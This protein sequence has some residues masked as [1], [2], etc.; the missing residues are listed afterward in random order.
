M[1]IRLDEQMR[2]LGT[3]QGVPLSGVTGLMR[4]L[5]GIPGLE[6]PQRRV[7]VGTGWSNPTV[8][9]VVPGLR[10]ETVPP[11]INGVAQIVLDSMVVRLRD[12]LGFLSLNGQFPLATFVDVLGPGRVA[13]SGDLV[14]TLVWSTSWNGFVSGV[15]RT[16]MVV[17][18]ANSV[19]DTEEG[20][21]L[22]LEATTRHQVKP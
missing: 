17:V 20:E 22:V 7:S 14:G 11:T 13:A 10:N 4:I 19:D 12:T 15:S 9:S 8:A 18:R 5:T 6:L 16:R 3:N 2:V 1:Q 21:E